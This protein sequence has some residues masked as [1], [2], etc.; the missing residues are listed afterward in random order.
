MA[1]RIIPITVEGRDE[2]NIETDKVQTELSKSLEELKMETTLNDQP[3]TSTLNTP[4]GKVK[5]TSKEKTPKVVIK[6]APAPINK[7]HEYLKEFDV[8]EK[9]DENNIVSGFSY[10]SANVQ[11]RIVLVIDSAQDENYTP[12]TVGNQKYSPLTTIK[13]AVSI[14]IKLKL[15]INPCHQFAIIKM[16]EKNASKVQDFCSDFRKLNDCLNK[17]TECQAEDIFDLNTVFDLIQ[18]DLPAVGACE[19]RL[20]TPY[21][22]RTILF[23]GRSYTIPEIE[24]T[25]K[26]DT[27]FKHPFS[28]CDILMTHEPIE[29]SN[30]CQ[31][32]FDVLQTL[33]KKGISY[34]F[35]VGRDSKRMHRCSGKLLGHPFQRPIQK[36]I[37]N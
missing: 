21:V 31:K 35:P 37:K 12:F 13:R 3:S 8:F 9:R 7:E 30:H 34:F 5:A 11:E 32:I 18:N 25:E 16:N 19:S 26:L 22:L 24:I 1:E 17:I 33:D 4:Q 28:V 14:F 23:Y 36:L 2:P 15:N 20:T 10:P 27:F 29:I 6:R